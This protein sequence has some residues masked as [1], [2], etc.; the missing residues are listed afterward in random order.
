MLDGIFHIVGDHQGGQIVLL[1]DLVGDLQHL[2]GGFRI[3]RRGVLV[4][5]QQLG[6][7]DFDQ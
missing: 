1:I 2:G 7:P 6:Y 3:Q 4:Q 5:K